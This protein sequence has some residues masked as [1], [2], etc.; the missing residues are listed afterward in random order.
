MDIMRAGS[1]PSRPAPAEWF[2]GSV[3]MDP[4]F[5]PAAPARAQGA[6]MTF[7]TGARTA[8]HTHPLGQAVIVTVGL[9]WAQPEGGPSRPGQRG[10]IPS[11]WT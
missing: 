5:A 8:W 10:L 7:E 9:G 4:L 11:A 3:R 1:R 2:T 6:L